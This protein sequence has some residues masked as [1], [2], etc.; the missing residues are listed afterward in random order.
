MQ[1]AGQLRDP[2]DQGLSF[3]LPNMTFLQ[4][5]GVVHSLMS[6][7]WSK[8]A[9]AVNVTAGDLHWFSSAAQISDDGTRVNVMLANL[10]Y[11]V[12]TNYATITLLGFTPAPAADLYVVAEPGTGPVNSTAGNTPA[13]PTYVQAVRTPFA[14]PATGPIVVTLPPL[15]FS[16]LVLTRA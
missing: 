13:N 10:D 9:L 6:S 16:I 12:S 8:N 11:G 3:F 5:P 7:V 15:S 14:V 1:R 4:P 2:W